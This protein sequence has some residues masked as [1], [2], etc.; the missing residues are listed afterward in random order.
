[1]LSKTTDPNKFTSWNICEPGYCVK[2]KTIWKMTT[3]NHK[4]ISRWNNVYQMI[5]IRTQTQKIQI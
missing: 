1:M 5:N 3:F 4:L 2:F